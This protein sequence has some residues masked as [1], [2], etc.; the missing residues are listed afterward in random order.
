MRT[1]APATC[2]HASVLEGLTFLRNLVQISAFEDTAYAKMLEMPPS[3]KRND[4]STCAPATYN[5][6]HLSISIPLESSKFIYAPESV[7]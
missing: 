5:Q 6:T 3:V 4:L 2:N 1:R 7:V